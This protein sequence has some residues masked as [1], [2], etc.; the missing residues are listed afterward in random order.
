MRAVAVIAVVVYHAR[1]SLLPGGYL[2]VDI[3]FVISGFLIGRMIMVECDDGRFSFS[4]FYLRRAARLLPATISTV[5]LTTI[6][7]IFFLTYS[8]WQDYIPQLLGSL[9]F[10]ANIS[11]M[12]QSSYFAAAAESKPL[13]HMWSLSLE[14]QFYLIAPV[15]LFLVPRQWRLALLAGALLLSLLLCLAVMEGW[16]PLPFSAK[17][18]QIIAFYML[19]TRAWELLAGCIAAW[20][21]L[22]YPDFKVP[23]NL[24]RLALAAIVALLVF[25]EGGQHPGASAFLI[26]VATVVVLVG[27]DGW[28]PNCRLRR[29]AVRIGDWSYSI[30]LLHWPLHAFAYL[31][32]LGKVPAWA[33]ILLALL[34]VPLAALQYRFVETPFRGAWRQAP[35]RLVLGAVLCCSALAVLATPVVT[36]ALYPT[37]VRLAGPT[38]NVGLSW[39]CDQRSD[40]FIARPVCQTAAT[41]RVALLGD[42]IAMQWTTALAARSAEIGGVVQITKSACAPVLGAAHTSRHRTRRW[43]E[44]CISFVRDSVEK[45]SRDP[46][47]RHVILSPMFSQVFMAPDRRILVDGEIIGPGPRAASRGLR[48]LVSRL[49]AAGKH[50]VLLGPAPDNGKNFGACFERLATGALTFGRRSCSLSLDAFKK[51]RQPMI[52]AL[53]SYLDQKGVNVL[54]P[55]DVLCQSGECRT[56][57]NRT[58]YYVDNAHL[59]VEGTKHV[60]DGLGIWSMLRAR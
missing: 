46:N 18:A 36:N 55:H 50:V 22:R 31:G 9:G 10:F 58:P 49:V 41:P 33:A 35:R 19:P 54:W 53:N 45:I 13:L 24:K 23:S 40:A 59:T 7:A 44:S 39:I 37:A 57:R 27:Q 52:D 12:F 42:S 8:G 25:A 21:M 34:S 5:T 11:L 26:C 15:L 20:F 17:R 6:G 51:R 32:W 14:E 28:L 47:I 38:P 60:L 3:F 16:L 48:E 29:G 43:A 30:Y 1:N 56:F 4:R 2:G